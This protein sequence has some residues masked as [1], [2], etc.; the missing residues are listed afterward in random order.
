M[1]FYFNAN[2][3][4]ESSVINSSTIGAT[5]PDTGAFTTLDADG[6]TTLDQTTIDTTDGQFQVSGSNAVDIDIGATSRFVTSAGNITIDAEAGSTT[7]DGNTSLTAQ[8]V[9][10]VDVLSGAILT[11]NTTG[12]TLNISN[13]NVNQ[14]LNI[15]T[16]TAVKTLNIGNS[17]GTGSVVINTGSNGF[18]L[19]ATGASSISTSSGA[20]SLTG[21]NVDSSSL[22]RF[23]NATNCTSSVTGALV[24]TGGVGIGQDLCVG[25]NFDI[26]GSLLT[27]SVDTTSA[28]ILTL[29]PS[30]ATKV[31]IADTGVETEIQ[32]NLDVLDT[33]NCTSPSTGSIVTAGGVGIALDLCVGGN[34]VISG[35]LTV[36]GTTTTV[37]SETII[38]TDN[39]IHVNSGPISSKDGGLLVQRYQTENDVATGD[40]IGDTPF[41]S[42][43]AQTGAAGT[44]T[45]AAGANAADDFYNNYWIEITGGTGVNQVRQ[46]TDYVGATKVATVSGWTVTPDATSTYSLYNCNYAGSIFDEGNNEWNF[47]CSLESSADTVSVQKYLNVHTNGIIADGPININD[48]TN[49]TNS[50]TGA[51]IVDGGVGIGQDLCVGGNFDIGGSLLTDS[52]DTT[53]AGILTLGPSIATKVEIADTGVETEIQGN[54]DVLDTTNCTSPSTGSIVTAGGVGIALDLCVGGTA[55]IDRLDSEAANTLLIGD[56]N[57]T[58]VEIADTGIETEVQGTLDVIEA[59]TFQSTVQVDDIDTFTATTL[60]LGKATATKVEI[61]DTGIETEVQGTLDVI[62]AATFQSTLQANDLD[63]LTA[64]TLLLGKA[65]ATKVEIAD[66]GIETEIQGPLDVIDTTNCTSITTGSIVT[67]GGI[68]VALN[69]CVGG[70]VDITGS[71]ITNSVDTKTATILTL[72]PSTATKVEIADTGVETEIQ[73]NLDVLDTTNCTSPSTGSIVTAGGVG[74][75]LDLCVGG[76]AFID[77]LDSEAANTLLI[78]D[79]NATKVEIADTGVETEVQGD[80]DVIGNILA[81]DLD[82]RTATTLLLGKATATKVE[83][84]DTGVETEIQGNLDI[85]D[86]TNCT[87]SSTGSIVT[88]GGVGITLD[89]CVGGTA[90]ID[91]LDSEAANTLLIGDVNATKVEIADTGVETEVQG[92][93]DILDA[94]NCTNSTT[95]SITT[96]GGVGIVKDLCVGGNV[97]ITGNLSVTGNLTPAGARTDSVERISV[98]GAGTASPTLSKTVTFVTTTAGAGVASGTMPVGT[99]DGEHK[100]IIMTSLAV[101]YELTMGSTFIDANGGSSPTRKFVFKKAGQSAHIMWDDTASV[102]LIVGGSGA[103]VVA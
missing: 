5:V 26:G 31:E 4:L 55:F 90:F 70:N 97:D 65:I 15:G 47:I 43:T 81:N 69:V 73:G 21:N 34:A 9:G 64:T 24:V 72:G 30:I 11:A 49:C 33:T 42:D 12:A 78:G 10:N 91:R 100:Y 8:S 39:I 14:T 96:A 74:I 94:T 36:E 88:A 7:I 98:A 2:A 82:T 58:K 99:L 25:G 52:V 95:G 20:L 6:I 41:E 35:N 102:W 76:T 103:Q 16:G 48:T 80:L 27:D 101:N 50:T 67:A 79:V 66:T 83:I 53:S 51:L 13:N 22:V 59:A 28:G 62:E 37:E 54:L 68:G 56:V 45:L 61:A 3:N 63:T 19:S 32:G 93:L 18:S 1:A 71:L 17:T 92:N 86:T 89:L 57:A 84:A 44:I 60:L 29:G 77:R 40:V 38:I 87:S 46:I 23:T 85:L 75:A